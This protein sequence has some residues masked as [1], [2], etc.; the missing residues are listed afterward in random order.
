[1]HLR[2]AAIERRVQLDE[3]SALVLYRA[4]RAADPDY[5]PAQYEYIALMRDRFQGV[6]LRREFAADRAA[7][8]LHACL[9]AAVQQSAYVDAPLV[10]LRALEATHG[11][12]PCTDEF[13]LQ[14]E[15]GSPGRGVRAMRDSPGLV[16]TWAAV[17]G[18]LGRARRWKEADQIL[19][20]GES[21]V[22]DPIAKVSLAMGRITQLTSRHDTA[23]ANALI[24]VLSSGVRRD[25][26]AGVL[27]EYLAQTC[28]R[29][30][31]WP[32]STGE[33]RAAACRQ[34]DA[35]V[36][37]RHAWFT[38]WLL[39]RIRAKALTE[40][41][42]LA[43]A[44]PL[45]ARFVQLSDSAGSAALRVI[46]YTARGRA[47]VKGG[48]LSLALRDL[49]HAA[50]L[51]PAA[52]E[53]YYAAEAYHNLA[54]VYEGGGRFTEA[55]AAAD[56]FAAIA[57]QMPTSVQRMMSRYDAGTI[58]WEAGWHAAAVTDFD[59]M[60][61]IV[62]EQHDGHF[63]AGEYFEREGQLGRALEYYRAGTQKDSEP[64]NLAALARVYEALGLRDSAEALAR[65]H[66][67]AT[68][69]WQILDRPLLPDILAR[70]GRV[71]EA[72]ALA[73]DWATHESLAGNIAGAAIAYTRLAELLLD[74]TPMAAFSAAKTADSL[75][76][77]LHLVAER[78][79]AK[80]LEGR[81]LFAAGLRSR[82]VDELRS[83]VRLA[84]THPSA[85]GRLSANLALGRALEESGE[86]TGAMAAYERAGAAVEAM[87][88]GL[89]GDADRSGYKAS[90]LAPF[91]GA[92]R[93]LF[94]GERSE[95]SAEAALSWS[96]RRKAA[97]LTLAGAPAPNPHR[98]LSVAT[99]RRNLAVDDA[100][101]D[102]TVLDSF[103]T[104]IVVRRQRTT[105]IPL[106]VSPAQL[107]A[108]VDELRRPLLR[109]AGGQ[110][111]LAHAPFDAAAAETLFTALVAP[112]AA[113]LRDVKRLAIAPDGVMWYVPFAALVTGTH[114]D[115]TSHRKASE[116]LVERYEL[117]LLPS[118]SFFSGDGAL[119]KKNF[120]VEALTYAVGDGPAELAAI[121]EAVG[122]PRVIVRRNSAANEHAALSSTADVLHIAAHGVVD[123]RDPL[124][125]HIALARGSA[126]DG[127]L[128]SSEI[129]AHRI[130]PRLVVL[131][132]C[133]A[134]SGRLYAGEGLVG[135]ARSFLVAGARQVVAS[136]WPVDSSVAD[137]TRIF[138]RK[139]GAGNSVASALRA[140]Q[141]SV[142]AHQATSHPIHWAGFV[143]FDGR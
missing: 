121:G 5:F 30:Q 84:E 66:D 6:D 116:Y 50:A 104:A 9:V 27:A 129:A 74:H 44:A 34:F 25:A 55:A 61:R 17:A 56:S 3:D 10:R 131:T 49:A 41:G 21:A 138:Y 35:L 43:A 91:N 65:A 40:S 99:L 42:E 32:R 23:A 109:I 125:S 124:A 73:R 14:V 24:Q 97:A 80:T 52:E 2:A 126:D 134:V 20:A 118:A 1:M 119:L 51:G 115:G 11:P 16:D 108:W 102:F 7:P 59:A 85:A 143:T 128:H 45:L 63:Y 47:F 8:A 78:I 72:V 71:A 13:L 15:P 82:G 140:A 22:D 105:M 106:H 19:R 28:S 117:R 75:S 87:T 76:A 101:V 36:H 33:S 132:A 96:A 38:E 137:L 29:L 127:L 98:R 112:L 26:R 103:V 114:T 93:I 37:A 133:E 139:L 60:V 4:A 130:A 123:D 94:R 39:V 18:S 62:D 111:D 113:H 69:V 12:S 89:T 90:H 92:L 122:P 95:A 58:R 48:R 136:Q 67:A 120:T 110:L 54:H 142:L 53:P 31:P 68:E 88:S 135:L 77:S 83:A 81:S 57:A 70:R 107:S 86:L 46:A 141:L 64:R 79:D 100:L